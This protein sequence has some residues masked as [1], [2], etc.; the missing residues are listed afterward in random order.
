[1]TELPEWNLHE[2]DTKAE[3]F[4][5]GGKNKNSYK[6]AGLIIAP[7]TVTTKRKAGRI[8]TYHYLPVLVTTES[9]TAKLSTPL[10]K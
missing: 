2:G 5:R 10:L 8:L 1:L 7:A 4:F 6:G 3:S 9:D